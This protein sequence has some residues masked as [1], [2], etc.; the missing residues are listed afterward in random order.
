MFS[1]NLE[2]IRRDGWRHFVDLP[3]ESAFFDEFA[4]H[5]EALP[6]AEIVRFEVNGILEIWVEF[7]F[8]EHRF[9]VNN[10]YS[11]YQF[12]VKD[13]KCPEKILLEIIAHFEK[14]VQK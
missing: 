10:Q 3:V 7:E 9:A 6:G 4:D 2:Q 12:Y 8:R 14:L 5:L 11:D 1:E 13:D